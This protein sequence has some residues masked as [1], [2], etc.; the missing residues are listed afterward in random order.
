MHRVFR[1]VAAAACVALVNTAAVAA[2][3]R[4]NPADQTKC[5][6]AVDLIQTWPG[7]G[8]QLQRAFGILADLAERNPRSASPLA[9]FAE[10]KYRLYANGQAAPAEVV[11]LADRA[12]KLDPENADAQVI[13]SKIM[14]DQRQVNA[15][16]RAAQESIRLAPD[17]PEAMFQMAKVAQDATRY[18]EA[19]GWYRKAI[20]RLAHKQRKSNVYFHL[21]EMLGAREPV[22]IPKTAAAYESAADLTDDSIPILNDAAVFLMNNTERYDRAIGFVN[23]ARSIADY[24]LGR[25]NLGLL[26]YFKWGHATMHPDRYRNAKDRPWDPE[27]ITAE[28]GVS[29]EFAFATNPVVTGTP[30]ATL[31]ML[32][33]DMIKDIDAFPENCECPDNALI[34]SA[35]GNH[36]D[37]VKMLVAKGANVNAVD[38]KYGSTALFYAVRYQNL[39]MVGHLV[40]HGAR[41][42]LQDKHGILL[43]EYAVMDAKPQDA[44]V[45]QLLLEKGGDADAITQ[46]GAPLVAVTVL[47]GKPAALALLVSKYKADP[48]ARLN[49]DRGDPILALAARNTHA[50]GNEM[51]RILLEAG[52]NPWV[53]AQG[54]DVVDSLASTKEVFPITGDMPP[55]IRAAHEAMHR[56]AD[57]TVAMLK[58]ARLKTP[59]PAG[60]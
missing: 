41:I 23:K 26:Q 60:F 16:A 20:D 22:D 7:S 36:P 5:D 56:A 54:V 19:E 31:A 45:L 47:R 21:A 48:N 24:S 32:K 37:V 59:K 39:E 10:L 13:Y 6:E 57:K 46:K 58:Q 17:K 38:R 28:T 11:Q 12:V 42:N 8:D 40:E 18:D 53:K 15:A 35:H 50:D 9:A 34:A 51:V 44:R 4:L 27:R 25:Q 3:V 55:Q 29:R 2:G 43:V 30:Y 52:A 1:G 14:L 49:A 33:L